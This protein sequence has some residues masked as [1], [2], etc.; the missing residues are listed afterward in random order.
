MV[1]NRESVG[2]EGR[3]GAVR[4]HP[5]RAKWTLVTP[6][7][8]RE[9]RASHRISRARLAQM[10]GVSS[11][12]VQNWETGT[13]ASFKIQRR[14]AELFATGPALFTVAGRIGA[15]WSESQEG[16]GRPEIVATGAIVAKFVES[17]STSAEELINLIRSVRQ[18]LS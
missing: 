11:T 15:P 6:E 2:E 4:R 8:L 17:R 12:S 10:L 13:V 1:H 14:L 3:R 7:Q 18:A 16:D 5:T 9:Y